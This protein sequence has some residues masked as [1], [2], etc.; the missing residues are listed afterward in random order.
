MKVKLLA[1]GLIA[2]S[3]LNA[4]VSS[5]LVLANFKTVESPVSMVMPAQYFSAEI[6]IESSEDDW[7]VKL[8]GIDDA[9]RSL[10]EAAGKEGFQVKIDRALVFTQHYDSFSF[11][12]SSDHD[13]L[14]DV[15]LLAPLDERTNLIQVVKRFR[16]VITGLKP[17][18]RV[19][20][21][22]GSLFLALENPEDYRMELLKKI[23]A[24]VDATAKAVSDGSDYS[25][26][27]LDGR[28]QVR[29]SGE[30]SV[31]VYI[32]FQVVYSQKKNGG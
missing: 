11:S 14:S 17:A 25:I 23:R 8:A 32:P 28:V 30:R 18:K 3:V 24:H 5:A 6:R 22:L 4:G 9:R 16:A 13:A 29:Q 10:I 26:S 21:S 12:K 31:E 2:G 20:V 27:G 19:S 7:S 1:L 15:L